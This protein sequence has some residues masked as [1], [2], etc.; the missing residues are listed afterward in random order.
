[1]KALFV[2]LL[3]AVTF[4][5][6]AQGTPG[7]VTDGSGQIVKTGSGLCLHSGS[8]T[9]ADAVKGCDPVVEKK[10]I[11]QV[12]S[13]DVM[14]EFDSAVLTVKGKAALDTLALTMKSGPVTVVGHADIIGTVKY[15]QTLSVS[16]AN[17]VAKYLAVKASDL[18]ITSSGVGSTQPAPGTEL[19]KGMKNFTKL[20]ACLA[21]SRRVV[22]TY[23][24]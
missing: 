16:R 3:S 13:S 18:K 15:N 23:V 21:P 2:I 4:L 12:F 10:V 11:S 14:F 19:C 5:A 6:V 22:I 8:Y 24:K 9:P 20:V 7:Y 17:S 1:M